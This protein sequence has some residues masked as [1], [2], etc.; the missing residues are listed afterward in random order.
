M[1][2]CDLSDLCVERSRLFHGTA[3]AGVVAEVEMAENDDMT[4]VPLPSGEDEE[5]RKRIRRSNDRDQEL[6]R[7]G[8]P[9]RHNQGY[10]EAADGVPE[11]DIE[12]I[13]DE[14]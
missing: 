7:E 13:V 6:E 10:D 11:P 1:H 9:A 5:E 12:H 4:V 8:R 2:L 14:P 3:L